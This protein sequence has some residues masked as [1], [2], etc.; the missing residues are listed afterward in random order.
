MR[1]AKYFFNF[2]ETVALVERDN[3]QVEYVSQFLQKYNIESVL[4]SVSVVIIIIK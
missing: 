2:Q 3:T 4:G 1:F